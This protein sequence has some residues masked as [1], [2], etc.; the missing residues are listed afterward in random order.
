MLNIKLSSCGRPDNV[1]FRSLQRQNRTNNFKIQISSTVLNNIY[2]NGV[3]NNTIN[4]YKLFKLSE[5]YFDGLSVI[6]NV[7]FSMVNLNEHSANLLPL[8]LKDFLIVYRIKNNCN[9]KIEDIILNFSCVVR[10]A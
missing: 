4:S 1:Q 9:I 2:N 6:C 3:V 10:S 8:I 5:S 7:T